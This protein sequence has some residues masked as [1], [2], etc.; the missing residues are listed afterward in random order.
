M[1]ALI[2]V[3]FIILGSNIILLNSQTFSKITYD[4]G[5]SIDISAG[6][7]VCADSII[8]NGTFSG[9]GTICDGPLPIELTSFTFTVNKNN[10][11]IKWATAWE[12]NNSGFD[13][14]RLQIISTGTA[15][16]EKA[17]FVGG[18]GTTNELKEYSFEDKKLKSGTYKYRLK[19]IDYNGNYEYF[20]LQNN[21]TIEKPNSF[22]IS[23]NY[24]NPSNPKSKIDFELPDKTIVKI[25]LY[26][27]LGQEVLKLLDE[28][29]DGGYYSVGFDGTNLA[30][31]VYFYVINAGEFNA[32]KK[33][34][35]V[36]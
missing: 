28:V 7:D 34:I 33:M 6:A 24:P 9:S 4:A 19:Q 22:S 1:K 18:N 5:T 26:N 27:L 21:V 32:V 23:Q 13:I 11:T 12:L 35:L 30:S 10:V 2:I 15:Q 3:T 20:D 29:K 17:G 31:G 25:K 36:K 14:D 16:W 8:I